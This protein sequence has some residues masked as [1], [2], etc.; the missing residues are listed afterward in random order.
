MEEQEQYLRRDCL[1]LSGIPKTSEE[2]TDEI[3][4]EVATLMDVDSR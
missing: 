4:K 2:N 1:V 3:V